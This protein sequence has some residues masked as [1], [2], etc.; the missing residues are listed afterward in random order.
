MQNYAQERVVDLKERGYEKA[1]L[2]DPAGVGGTHVMY[3]LH[4]ADQPTLYSGL[5]AAPSIS[6][7]VGLW[8]GVAKP[9]AMA[10]LG[11][12]AV[13]SLFHYITKGPNDVSKALEDEM[14]RK[15]LQAQAHAQ[16]R[17]NLDRE[18]MP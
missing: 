15:D 5:P 10:A 1:G 4:H 18:T 7:L 12:A 14:E 11:A 17:A 8:K 2:Y 3:V 13:G 16:A 9:L 6:P